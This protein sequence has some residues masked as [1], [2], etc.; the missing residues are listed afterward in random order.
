MFLHRF[1]N[2]MFVNIEIENEINFWNGKVKS[3]TANYCFDCA[4]ADSRNGFPIQNL[5]EM[6]FKC[7]ML[8]LMCVYCSFRGSHWFRLIV[9]TVTSYDPICV[10]HEYWKCF[11]SSFVMQLMIQRNRFLSRIHL[12]LQCYRLPFNCL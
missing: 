7:Q 12:H 10:T 3:L 1:L 8:N 9:R 4:S 6:F 2:M 5:L 11:A